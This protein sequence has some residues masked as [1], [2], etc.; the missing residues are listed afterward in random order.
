M[1]QIDKLYHLVAGAAAA[2][3]MAVVWCIE[4]LI[5]GAVFAAHPVAFAMVN[6]AMVA[7]LVKEAADYMDN[8]NA[9]ASGILMHSVD[10]WDAVA[11]CAGGLAVAFIGVKGLSL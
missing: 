7:G 3:F 4:D 10:P 9:A 6:A 8:K 2:A 1:K 5:F 11:T